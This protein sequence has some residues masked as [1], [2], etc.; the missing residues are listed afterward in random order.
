MNHAHMSLQ[1]TCCRAKTAASA[2]RSGGRFSL[3]DQTSRYELFKLMV[4]S[5]SPY[6][7]WKLY[8]AEVVEFVFH[9]L[10][11]QV[12]KLTPAAQCAH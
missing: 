3:T 4:F 6:F 2:R 12:H 5:R 10:Q 9:V 1:I 8:I 11:L 7:L